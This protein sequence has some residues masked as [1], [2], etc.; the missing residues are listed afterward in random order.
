MPTVNWS[1]LSNTLHAM[2]DFNRFPMRRQKMNLSCHGVRNEM[3][4]HAGNAEISDYD[5]DDLFR[6]RTPLVR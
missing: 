6:K 1:H 3:M 5:V 2:I 4:G